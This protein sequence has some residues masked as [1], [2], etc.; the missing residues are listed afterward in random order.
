VDST[1]LAHFDAIDQTYL[2]EIVGFL[3]QF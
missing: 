3:D 2:E 1:E